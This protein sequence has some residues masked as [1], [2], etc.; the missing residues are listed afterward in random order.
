M[1]TKRDYEDWVDG[2]D[3]VYTLVATVNG[4]HIAKATGFTVDEVI[5]KANGLDMQVAQFLMGEYQ[6]DQ[7]DWDA[8][9]DDMAESAG[10]NV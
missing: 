4:D 2:Q 7:T 6:D 10:Y 3:V 5:A 8:I 1:Q 9:A